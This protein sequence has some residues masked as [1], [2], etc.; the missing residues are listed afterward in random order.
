MQ[1]KKGIRTPI[2]IVV[3]IIVIGAKTQPTQQLQVRVF[4]CNPQPTITCDRYYYDRSQA[5][6][7]FLYATLQL[8]GRATV[9]SA[10][11]PNFGRYHYYYRMKPIPAYRYNTQATSTTTTVSVDPLLYQPVDL[12]LRTADLLLPPP[13]AGL[14]CHQ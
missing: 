8:Y 4:T 14:L 9:V 5:S 6:L 3:I 13:V 1:T 7:L 2:I 11:T 12:L 10:A